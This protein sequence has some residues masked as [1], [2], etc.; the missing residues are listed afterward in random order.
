METKKILLIVVTALPGDL[1]WVPDR[2][3]QGTVGDETVPRSY[4]METPSG[5][6]NSSSR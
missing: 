3:E 1:V 6:Y 5:T 2:R 4:E